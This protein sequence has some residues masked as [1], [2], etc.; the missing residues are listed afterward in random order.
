MKI[1]RRQQR[2]KLGEIDIIAMD[3]AQ[4]VFVEVK[5]RRSGAAGQ[6]F[7]AVDFRKQQ[8]LTRLALAW[9]KQHGRLDQSARFDVVSIIWPDDGTA[10]QID[11]FRN[12][13]E[14]TGR[15]QMFS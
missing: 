4:I 1:L 13:F 8:K 3:G 9:L 10:P 15:G 5:T 11:H 14:P 12:A 2:T 7:E 6:P